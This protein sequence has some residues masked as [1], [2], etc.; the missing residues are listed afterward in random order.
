M[1]EKKWN[2]PV[3]LPLTSDVNKFQIHVIQIVE[4]SI[5]LLKTNESDEKAYRYLV[6]GT[7][8]LIILFNRRRIGDVQYVYLESYCGENNTLHQRRG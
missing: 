2:K 7:L 1:N 4:D 6:E 8:A 5:E 3:I